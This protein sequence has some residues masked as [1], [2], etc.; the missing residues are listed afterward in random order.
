MRCSSTRGIG[1]R[2]RTSARAG[3]GRHAWRWLAPGLVALAC[4]ASAQDSPTLERI[5]QTGVITLGYRD[6]SIP[7]SYLDQRQRP[8]GYSMDLCLRIA[9]AVKAHLKLDDLLIKL[10]SVTSATRIAMVANRA[11]DLECGTTTN[12]VGRQERVAFAVTTFIAASRFVAKRAS[13]LQGFNDLRGKTVVSTAG[14][15]SIRRLVELNAAHDLG[16]KIIAGRDHAESFRMVETDRASAYVM[17]DVLLYGLIASSPQPA[18]YAV[19]GE[20]LSVEPYGIA[21]Q[22]DDPAFKKLADDTLVSLFR[23]GEIHRIYKRWFHSPI[24]PRQINLNL[25]MSAALAKAIAKPTDSGDPAD[26]R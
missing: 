26:Y 5:R 18:S 24:P 17:D 2:S 11:V 16:M 7:F 14:T 21:L 1:T 19:A 13:A 10:T 15:T 22:K 25:P 20:P 8:I 4:G 9:D 23:S 12:T 3:A 6:A